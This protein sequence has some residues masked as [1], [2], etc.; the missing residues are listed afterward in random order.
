[1]V[2]LCIIHLE[3]KR[4]KDKKSLLWNSEPERTADLMFNKGFLYLL[5]E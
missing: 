2:L 4:N 5:G 1:M 3:T